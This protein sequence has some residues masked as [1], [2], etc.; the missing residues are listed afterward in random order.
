MHRV[1]CLCFRLLLIVTNTTR[2]FDH[3]SLTIQS[4]EMLKSTGVNDFVKD[5]NALLKFNQL[6]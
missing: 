5:V 4:S 1:N 6:S 3:N 2:K